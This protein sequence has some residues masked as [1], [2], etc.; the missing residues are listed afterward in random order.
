M[1]SDAGAGGHTVGCLR[2]AEDHQVATGG[3]R[4][5][6]A[7]GKRLT[8]VGGWQLERGKLTKDSP[9]RTVDGGRSLEDGH[10]K[11]TAVERLW[12][13]ATARRL[14]LHGC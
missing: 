10:G 6:A 3:C 8:V 7:Q 11:M 1:D 9:Q 5:T 2:A 12:R 14:L 4:K 13:M